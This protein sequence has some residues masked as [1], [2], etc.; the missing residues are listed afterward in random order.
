MANCPRCDLP[1]DYIPNGGPVHE[2]TDFRAVQ[3]GEFGRC[4][5]ATG[6]DLQSGPIFCGARAAWAANG[7][8]GIAYA[9]ERHK[10][11][12]ERLVKS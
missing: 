2:V 10:R 1:A 4:G 9:C 7:N 11:L 12:L 6:D 3:L 8:G 5:I